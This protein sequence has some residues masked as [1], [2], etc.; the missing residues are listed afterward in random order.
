[1]NLY[2]KGNCGCVICFRDGAERAALVERGNGCTESPLMIVDD[3]IAAR[4]YW[5]PVEIVYPHDIAAL[6]ARV[7]TLEDTQFMGGIMASEWAEV[8]KLLTDEV[9]DTVDQ[10]VKMLIE[11]RDGLVSAIEDSGKAHTKQVAALR[12]QVQKAEELLKIIAERVKYGPCHGVK[13]DIDAYFA[14]KKK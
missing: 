10:K 12:A 7:K 8:Q 3:I 2:F 6:R 9:G 14:E 1:M 5:R 13:M 4:G 11:A